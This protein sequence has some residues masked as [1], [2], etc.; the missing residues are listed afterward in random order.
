MSF[1]LIQPLVNSRV[2][3]LKENHKTD[4]APGCDWESCSERKTADCGATVAT[5]WLKAFK[6]VSQCTEDKEIKK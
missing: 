1:R 6:T 3:T 5:D 2:Q 4:S